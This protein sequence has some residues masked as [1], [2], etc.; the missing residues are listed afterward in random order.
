VNRV[1]YR[2]AKP[3]QGALK[4]YIASLTAIEP[5]T[6]TRDAAM[7]Y[8]INLYNAKTVDLVLDNYP[9]GGFFSRGPWD[10]DAVTVSGRTLSLN[11]IE[12]GMPK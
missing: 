10:E 12:H 7:A 9:V 5:T 6:L 8:W 11:D 4:G 3:A 2:A 1:N